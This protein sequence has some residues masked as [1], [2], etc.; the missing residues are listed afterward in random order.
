MQG[1][2]QYH[3]HPPR[4]GARRSS[5]CAVSSGRRQSCRSGPG[6]RRR[7]GRGGAYGAFESLE[8]RKLMANTPPGIT[9]SVRATTPPLGE[10]P[11]VMND[12]E[13][14]PV[15]PFFRYTV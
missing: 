12:H 5:R 2:A 8:E 9:I 3:T 15:R 4:A 10:V 11:I 14:A 13:N 1:L 6:A 7:A